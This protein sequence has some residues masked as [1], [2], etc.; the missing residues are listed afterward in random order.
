VGGLLSAAPAHALEGPALHLAFEEGLTPWVGQQDAFKWNSPQPPEFAEDG[1]AGKSLRI[2]GAGQML[3]LLFPETERKTGTLLFWVKE[4]QGDAGSRIIGSWGPGWS[5]VT[6]NSLQNSE[7]EQFLAP[8]SFPAL[9]TQWT[10]FGISWDNAPNDKGVMS[11]RVRIYRNGVRIQEGVGFFSANSILLGSQHAL[12]EGKSRLLDEVRLWNR[13]LTD[14]EVKQWYHADFQGRTEPFVSIPLLTHAP[15]VNGIID[16]TEWAGAARITGLLAAPSGELAVDQSAFFLGYDAEHLYVAMAGDM[17]ELARTRPAAVFERFVRAEHTARTSHVERDDV[18]ELILSPNYWQAETRDEP[19]NWREYRLL[20][21][22]V[23]GYQATTYEKTS[24]DNAWPVE[25]QTASR[26]S[27]AGWQIEA[28]I[29]LA[30]F[31]AAAPEPGA[32]W[33]LQLGRIWQ[34]LKETHDVWTWGHRLSRTQ[35]A[36]QRLHVHDAPG[37]PPLSNFGVMQFADRDEVVVRINRIGQLTDGRIDL[38]AELFNPSNTQHTVTVTAFTDT[39]DI[40]QS[41]PVTLAAGERKVV[42]FAR[43]IMDFAASRFTFTVAKPDGALLHRTQVGFHI[44]QRFETRIVQYPNYERYLVALNLGVFSDAPLDQLRVDIRFHNEAGKQVVASEDNTIT[45]YTP[46]LTGATSKLAFDPHVLSVTI[47]QGDKVLAVEK[48]PFTRIK[49]AVWWNNRL[50]YEDMD[51]DIVPYPWTDMGVK[52]ATVQ[53]WGRE[54]RFGTSLLPEQVTTL[55]DPILRSPMRVTMK[56]ADGALFDSTK[57]K[58][59][60]AWTKRKNT[61]VEG[62]RTAAGKGFSLKNTFW[63]EY[64]GLVWCTLTLEP[65]GKL[66]VEHLE[67][68]IPISRQFSDVS[69]FGWIGNGDGGIQIYQ[70]GNTFYLDKQEPVR[71][72]RQDGADTWRMTLVNTP[73]EF[74]TSYDI[75]LGFMATPGRPKTWRTPEYQGWDRRPGMYGFAALGGGPFYPDSHTFKP[76]PDPEG[77]GHG[78]TGC[79]VWTTHVNLTPDAV[80]AD[81]SKYYVEWLIN[82][83]QGGGNLTQGLIRPETLKSQSLRDWF[84]WRYWRYRENHGLTALYYD[85]VHRE[86]LYSRDIAKRLYNLLPYSQTAARVFPK[87]NKPYTH[88][89]GNVGGAAN[90]YIDLRYMNFWK[91]HWDGENLNGPIPQWKTYIGHLTPELFRAEYMGHNFAWPVM[92]LGQG[93]IKQEWADAHGGAE[94]AHDHLAGLAMLHD[95]GGNLCCHAPGPLGRAAYQR[96]YDTLD[97][98]RFNHWVYQFLPYWHQDIV[99]VPDKEM[100]ASWY[101]GQPSKLVNATPEVIDAYFETYQC[102]QLPEHMRKRIRREVLEQPVPWRERLEEMTDRAIL[103]FFNHSVWEGEVRL[104]V[105]WAKLGFGAPDT[106]TVDNAVH[107]RGIRVEK[108]NNDQG[109]EVEQGVFFDNPA[110]YARIENGELV[111]P[112]TKFNYRMIVL[113]KK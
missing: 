74:A 49:K 3:G 58:A 71:V 6:R 108:V 34:Q 99:Q 75:T 92:F 10:Q 86:G 41:E 62:I 93:R 53:V 83:F 85:N 27:N 38:Q 48:H 77:K 51:H 63:A 42:K 95:M 57:V 8:L 28:R 111:F 64:D 13:V 14:A 23:G 106:L 67:I 104:K 46:E 15:T 20:G 37:F 32:R 43:Q 82:P 33:G 5:A 11:G 81:D 31:G 17:T 60:T 91:Y 70:E 9:D 47:R 59:T 19:G 21:N 72:E 78:G 12:P 80:S 112:M 105:D 66:T 102:R 1:I 79:Y 98:L 22:A 40:N 24:V 90:G 54:Y 55:D 2:T 39:P 4:P 101:I 110:E 69:A 25:W 18:L 29:P 94:L 97:R 89:S 65:K 56:M 16:P 50:G 113:E 84:V 7:M 36:P 109:E 88:G 87:D 26:V 45:T 52:G 35:P 107:K 103:V 73:T 100:Y 44:E 30:S 96:W 61:R 68:E 76:G